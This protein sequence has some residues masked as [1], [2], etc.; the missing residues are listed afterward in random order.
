MFA[1]AN[2]LISGFQLDANS[3]SFQNMSNPAVQRY[4][5]VVQAV[6]LHAPLDVEKLKELDTLVPDPEVVAKNEERSREFMA[7]VGLDSLVEAPKV[8]QLS[9]ANLCLILHG[10]SLGSVELRTAKVEE[11]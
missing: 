11:E 3:F 10:F 5:A 4:F 2:N 9:L 7:A 8:S 1:A 6:A